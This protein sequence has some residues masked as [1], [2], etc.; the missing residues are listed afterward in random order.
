MNWRPAAC[1]MLLWLPA[2]GAQAE[3]AWIADRL[4]A[5]LHEDRTAA[6]TVLVL[7][8]S[9]TAVEVLERD[10]ALVKVRTSGGNEGWIDAM[11]LS[12]EKPAVVLLADVEA[13]RA[14]AVHELEAANERIDELQAALQSSHQQATEAGSAGTGPGQVQ[15][16]AFEAPVNSETLREMQRLAEENQRV[17]Q[18]LAEAEAAAAM[19]IERMEAQ[20]AETPPP[21]SPVDTRAHFLLAL[22]E[23]NRWQWLA[24]AGSLLLVFALG[25]LTAESGIRRRHG[26]FH[27]RV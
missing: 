6:S 19:A 5:G 26:G 24:L 3:T 23:W 11:Y 8:S 20:P 1:A 10:A 25:L 14:D 2:A 12:D 13:A 4:Q 21:A 22:V 18:Q 9:G 7:L 16:A 17:K 15:S 27:V